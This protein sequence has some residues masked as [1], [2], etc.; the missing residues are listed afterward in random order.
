MDKTW[1]I[2]III[3]LVAANIVGFVLMGADK[4]KARRGAW[5]IPEK[6]FFIVSLLGGSLGTFLGMMIFR[7]KTR[8]WYFILG[9]PLIMILQAGIAIWLQTR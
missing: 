8:H 2:I 6:T 4:S 1:M 9:I 3:Y 7:H 5:R